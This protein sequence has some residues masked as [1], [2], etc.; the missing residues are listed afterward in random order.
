ML[1]VLGLLSG[2]GKQIH[3]C[4]QI[5]A[6]TRIYIF[7][8]IYLTSASIVILPFPSFIFLSLFY[9]FS[10]VI[11]FRAYLDSLGYSLQ[12]NILKL[13]TF[14]NFHLPHKVAVTVLEMRTWTFGG[15]RKA[16]SSLPNILS[17]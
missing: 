12:L 16:L 10:S 11:I 17:S 2:H 14:A 4:I 7:L 5:P 3:V 9:E 8:S 1:R 13:V 6:Y 15:I